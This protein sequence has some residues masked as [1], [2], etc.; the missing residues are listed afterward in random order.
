MS[1]VEG[2]WLVLVAPV[3]AVLGVGA[4]SALTGYDDGLDVGSYGERDFQRFDWRWMT[5][6][7]TES[8]T[9]DKDCGISASQYGTTGGKRG[10]GTVESADCHSFV[11]LLVAPKIRAAFSSAPTCPAI[12]DDYASFALRMTDGKTFAQSTSG[13]SGVEPYRTVEAEARRLM[14][15]ARMSSSDFDSGADTSI[16]S[17]SSTSPDSDGA[18]ACSGIATFDIA[19]EAMAQ[20]I[21]A[22]SSPCKVCVQSVDD[23]GT[24]RQY[25]ALQVPSDCSCPPVM[26]K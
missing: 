18:D 24:P 17:D 8:V 1:P 6:G 21:C 12:T 22:M 9:F 4:C 19:T 2:R 16:A 13:C 10:S 14:S 15:Y 23:A 25:M 20:S 7:F 5:T 26:T 3:A 11:T